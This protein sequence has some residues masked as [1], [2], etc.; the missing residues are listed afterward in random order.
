MNLVDEDVFGRELREAVQG[1]PLV[2]PGPQLAAIRRRGTARRRRSHAAVAG[3]MAAV[4]AVAGSAGLMI[5]QDRPEGLTSGFASGGAEA[6]RGEQTSNPRAVEE[7]INSALTDAAIAYPA[8]PRDTQDGRITL[9][10]DGTTGKKIVWVKRW[11]ITSTQPKIAISLSVH[12][13]QWIPEDAY[14]CKQGAPDQLRS[15]RDEV[16]GTGVRLLSGEDSAG[17]FINGNDRW[18]MWSPSALAVYPDGRQV[19]ITVGLLREEGDPVPSGVVIEEYP[20]A[21]TL[22]QLRAVAADPELARIALPG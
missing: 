19:S 1:V 5:N 10:E 11:S 8:E 3:G 4:L 6:A 9:G 20:G 15:C 22:D 7:I 21:I 12:P 14:P 2:G 17:G 18:T 16:L 13:Q